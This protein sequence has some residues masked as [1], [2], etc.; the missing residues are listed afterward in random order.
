MIVSKLVLQNFD[1]DFAGGSM[2]HSER[3]HNTRPDHLSEHV[4]E[5]GINIK[6]LFTLVLANSCQQLKNRGRN[7]MAAEKLKS[8]S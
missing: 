4:K 7:L 2:F 8:V 5:Q 6:A 3:F 1:R